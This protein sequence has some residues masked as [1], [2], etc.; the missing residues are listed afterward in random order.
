MYPSRRFFFQPEGGIRSI[1]VTGV[2]TCALPI[3]H[4]MTMPPR[5]PTADDPC[6][7]RSPGS[8]RLPCV[9]GEPRDRTS[10]HEI[11]RASCRGRVYMSV[12]A[13][14]LEVKDRRT[15]L[16]HRSKAGE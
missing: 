7:A 5:Y 8:D 15:A 16:G 14:A 4:R 10:R 12:V 13:E 3:C 2:Q 11:G 1:G 6:R 9:A